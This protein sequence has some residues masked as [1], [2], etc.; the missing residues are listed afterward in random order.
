MRAQCVCARV[1]VS[2][3]H[4]QRHSV[5]CAFCLP[6]WGGDMGGDLAGYDGKIWSGLLSDYYAP[7]WELLLQAMCVAFSLRLK[8]IIIIIINIIIATTRG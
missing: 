2:L 4:R 3:V 8:S 6:V 5:D 7:V 1:R